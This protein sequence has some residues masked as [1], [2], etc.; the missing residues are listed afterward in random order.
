MKCTGF[1]RIEMLEKITRFG[2]TYTSNEIKDV[3]EV[4]SIIK[5]L[6]ARLGAD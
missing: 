4:K 6:L 2:N 3:D 5:Q 1:C